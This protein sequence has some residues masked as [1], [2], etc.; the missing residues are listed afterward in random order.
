MIHIGCCGF[1]RPHA[2]YF[3]HYHFIEIQ[4]SFYKPPRQKTAHRWRVEEAPFDFIF[5]LKAWQLIT[6]PPNSPTYGKAK[7]NIPPEARPHYGSFRP[8]DE[9]FDAWERTRQIAGILQAPVVLF[10]CPSSFTPT[11]EHKENMRAF[12]R[13]VDRSGMSF[14]WESRGSWEDEEIAEMC[15][16]LNLTHC[17]D[18]FSRSAV[19]KDIAYFRLHGIPR[20]FHS[21]SDD[22]LTQLKAW[23]QP[24][25]MVYVLFNNITM[26]EDGLRFREMISEGLE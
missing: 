25:E 9:V 7:I 4:S 20:Y 13:E 23:C 17:V 26:W 16:E 15:L 12:F 8:T 18:P 24:Y 14:A 19:T 1:E 10:Q 6:H 5:S 2:M 21:Y 22:E 11:I 3:E